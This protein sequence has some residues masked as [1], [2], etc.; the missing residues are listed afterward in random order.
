MNPITIPQLT[1][2]NQFSTVQPMNNAVLSQFAATDAQLQNYANQQAQNFN[3]I[4][5]TRGVT[6][7]NGQYGIGNITRDTLAQQQ[8]S[9]F[10]Y[11]QRLGQRGS[12]INQEENRLG[13]N[14]FLNQANDIRTL[15]SQEQLRIRNFADAAQ[16]QIKE[17]LS[18]AN[19]GGLERGGVLDISQ[20]LTNTL[21]EEQRK[22]AKVLADYGIALAAAEQNV[23]SLREQAQ[24]SV[25]LQLEPIKQEYELFN[26]QFQLN[27]DSFTKDEQT[28]IQAQIDERKRILDAGTV[29]IRNLATT[30]QNLALEAAKNGA[31]NDVLLAISGAQTPQEA[32]AKAG[33]FIGLFDRLQA[34]ADLA[35]TNVE[36]QKQQLELALAADPKNAKKTEAQLTAYGFADRML[37]SDKIINSIGSKFVGVSSVVGQNLPNTLK[38]TERQQFE[39][40]QRNFIN[41]VLRKESGA[42]ISEEE[43]DNARKQYFPQPGDSKEVLIQKAQNRQSVIKNNYRNAGIEY[44]V[45]PIQ[46]IFNTSAT[47]NS[48]TTPMQGILPNGLQFRVIN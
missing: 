40:A 21:N 48:T 33:Q 25:D 44:E 2:S 12:M 26:Q 36:I 32:I 6:F 42:V 35:K 31:P 47:S 34:Q 13:V 46:D 22:S 14:T 37:E 27:K 16:A 3:P 29:E 43:F 19:R 38:S 8:A 45:Q 28:R 18:N 24:R 1:P 11:G 15:Q 23:S 30:K 5:Q 4:G 41:A 7:N 39:Q 10:G 17:T 9:L 20:G